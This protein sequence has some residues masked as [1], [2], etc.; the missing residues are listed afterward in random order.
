MDIIECEC[1]AKAIEVV[2]RLDTSIHFFFWAQVQISIQLRGFYVKESEGYSLVLVVL[3]SA[4]CAGVPANTQCSK[5]RPLH[6][7]KINK[8]AAGK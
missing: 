2:Y 3:P 7:E 8:K 5:R 1:E 6:N 4:I